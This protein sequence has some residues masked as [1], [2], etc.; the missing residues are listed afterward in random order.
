MEWVSAKERLPDRDGR[1]VCIYS[2][3]KL[4]RIC[5][6]ALSGASLIGYGDNGYLHDELKD[7]RNIFYGYDYECGFYKIDEVN[8]WTAIPDLPDD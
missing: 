8:Y 6:F 5:D 4:L 1:Y 7:E 2:R 3:Y